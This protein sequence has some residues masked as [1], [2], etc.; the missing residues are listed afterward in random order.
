MAII[1]LNGT[2]EILVSKSADELKI[3]WAE[4]EKRFRFVI[5]STGLKNR[6]LEIDA[7]IRVR[8]W[9]MKAM[10]EKMTDA[11]FCKVIES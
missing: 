2:Q 4:T 5:D 11:E 7:I 1:T 10:Q 8:G 9:L 3:I 6:E